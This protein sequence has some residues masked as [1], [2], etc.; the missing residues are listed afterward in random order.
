M[1]GNK[2]K[3]YQ[4]LCVIYNI[5]PSMSHYKHATSIFSF[6]NFE[7]VFVQILIIVILK[8]T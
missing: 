6:N 2:Y 5:Y 7:Y 3:L 8:Y 1:A 4:Y